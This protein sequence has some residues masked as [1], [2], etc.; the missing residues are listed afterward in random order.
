[1]MC[2]EM[3]GHIESSDV[4]WTVTCN[5]AVWRAVI[6]GVVSI[7]VRWREIKLR[8]AGSSGRN[9]PELRQLRSAGSSGRNDPDLRQLR[10]AGSS[11]GRPS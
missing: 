9:D 6:G 5:E 1:M 8:S 4:A 2:D 3:T 7:A 11:G 10:S